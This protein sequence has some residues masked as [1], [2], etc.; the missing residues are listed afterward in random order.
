MRGDRPTRRG[1]AATARR[2]SIALAWSLCVAWLA[3]CSTGPANSAT[4][5]NQFRVVGVPMIE[6][7]TYDRKVAAELTEAIVKSVEA[8]TPYRVVRAGNADL[9]LRARVTKV[10]LRVLSK[11]RTT[12]LPGEMAYRLTVD[13]EWVEQ[14]T[15][16]VFVQRTGFVKSSMFVPSLPS[17]E[18]ADLGR[19]GAVENMADDIVASLQG[20]W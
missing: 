18:P 4:F 6:N 9:V 5:P 12:G 15:G 11:N 17:Q 3:G 7:E 16:K 10:E 8:Q 2:A 13:F 14:D 19:F 20:N 1:G